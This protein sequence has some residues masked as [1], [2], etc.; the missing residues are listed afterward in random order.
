[1]FVG[2]YF[3]PQPFGECS[4]A[5]VILVN[6]ALVIYLGRLLS[7]QRANRDNQK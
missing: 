1:M 7:Q 3:H 6:V 2:L 4:S 5:G